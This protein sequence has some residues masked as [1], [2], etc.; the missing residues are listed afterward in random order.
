MQRLIPC[1]VLAIYYF[2]KRGHNTFMHYWDRWS[3]IDAALLVQMA[4]EDAVTGTKPGDLVSYKLVKGMDTK[5]SSL[6][7]NIARK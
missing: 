7:C 2:F 4:E 1:W 6:L 3:I 5:K